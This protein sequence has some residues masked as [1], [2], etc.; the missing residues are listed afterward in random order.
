MS[1][2]DLESVNQEP[3]QVNALAMLP[4]KQDS[5]EGMLASDQWSGP[6][7]PRL[8]H[9]TRILAREI[10]RHD[11]KEVWSTCVDDTLFAWANTLRRTGTTRYR[12]LCHNYFSPIPCPQYR[13]FSTSD[14]NNM[15]NSE[16]CEQATVQEGIPAP[17]MR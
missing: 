17:N 15:N 16:R 12:C 6:R 10:S 9:S 1:L 11:T 5:R 8:D 4:Q 14:S 2:F 3:E 13:E 7:I